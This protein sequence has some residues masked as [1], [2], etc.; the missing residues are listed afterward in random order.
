MNKL[1]DS[2][3]AR[4]SFILFV[5]ASCISL[6]ALA[7]PEQCLVSPS[8]TTPCEHLIYKRL[9]TEQSKEVVC[10]CLQDFQDLI[11]PATT[12]EKTQEQAQKF[13]QLSEQFNLSE[14]ALRKLIQY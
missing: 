13:K 3:K 7:F 6:S 12:P 11:Y 10:V 14:E 2:T 5:M 9:V 4:L 1:I 8:R